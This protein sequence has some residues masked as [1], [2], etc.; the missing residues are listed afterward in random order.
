MPLR[1]KI[2]NVEKANETKM[3]DNAEITGMITAFGIGIKKN[4]FEIAKLLYNKIIIMIEA[5]VDDAH[6]AHIETLMLTFL[7]RFLPELI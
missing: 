6:I 7:Y 2:L 1:G 4:D 3:Y 5:D